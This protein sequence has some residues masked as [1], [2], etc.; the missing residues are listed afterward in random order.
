MAPSLSVAALS[1]NSPDVDVSSCGS[2]ISLSRRELHADGRWHWRQ[3]ENRA[4]CG[5]VARMWTLNN[6]RGN[7]SATNKDKAL[8]YQLPSSFRQ[9]HSV[10]SPPGSPHP[11]QTSSQSPHSLSPSHHLSLPRPFISELKLICFTNP[12][13]HSHSDSSRI[14]F[15]DLE[16]ALN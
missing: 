6:V 15:A 12:S 7:T 13:L 8:T 1:I 4:N 5:K 14:A 16:P 2:L 9:R 3:Q 10:H 11:A